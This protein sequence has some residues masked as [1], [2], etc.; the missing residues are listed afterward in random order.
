[1]QSLVVE[2]DAGYRERLVHALDKMHFRVR[3][4]GSSGAALDLLSVNRF[5]LTVLD[6]GIPGPISGFELAKRISPRIGTI[7]IGEKPFGE[8]FGGDS[9]THPFY[10]LRK[11]IDDRLFHSCLKAFSEQ[12]R[13]QDEATQLRR[14]VRQL[15][16]KVPPG[17]TL[18]EVDDLWFGLFDRMRR[19]AGGD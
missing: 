15:R 2:N 3:V 4:A 9:W 14:E 13:R 17:G 10:Y 1:M 16:G 6:L 7:L 18:H 8:E 11:P 19:S 12:E 5:D